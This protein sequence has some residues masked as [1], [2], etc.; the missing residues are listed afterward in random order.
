MNRRTFQNRPLSN[1]ELSHIAPSAFA[2]EPWHAQSSRYA[3]IPTSRVI[4]GMREAGFQPYNAIQSRTRIPGKSEFTKHLI[5]FRPQN[6]QLANVGDTAVEVVLVN[7]HD[8]SSRYELSAGAFRLA[9]LNG[10]MVAESMIEA[11]K[12]RHTGNVISEVI[13]ATQRILE[14]APIVAETINR[15]KTI[16]LS[17]AEARILAEEAH[18]LRFENGSP[19]EPTRLLQPRRRE[20]NGT[21]LWTTFNR[22]QENTVTG[23]LRTYTPSTHDDNGHYVPGRRNSTR[24]VVGIAENTKLNRALWSL[25][26]KM[27]ELKA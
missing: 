18:S 26:E 23:G 20:D 1:E 10:L 8:G 17:P 22:I 5:R 14:R 9:C 16:N 7:S 15:W 11:I 13:D 12:I 3:F 6:N 4:D 27:A 19:V 25:A 24:A 21:D 2:V